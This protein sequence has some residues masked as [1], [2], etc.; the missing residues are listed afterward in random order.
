MIIHRT[1]SVPALPARSTCVAL[2]LFD[3]LHIGHRAVLEATLRMAREHGA[4]PLCFT[5]ST[6]GSRPDAK[7]D[8]TRLLTGTQ[9]AEALEAMGFAYM[10]CPP[11][12]EFRGLAPRAFVTGALA[13]T[14]G[15]AGVLCGYDFRFGSGAAGTPETLAALCG[16]LGLAVRVAPA[17]ELDGGPVSSRRIRRLVADGEMEAAARLL[18]RPFSLSLRVERGRGLGRRLGAPTLNQPLPDGLTLPRFGV[19]ASLSHLPGGDICPGVTNVGRRPTVGSEAPLAET[20]LPGYSGDLYGQ[21]VTVELLRFLRAEQRFP[22][23]ESLR[24]QIAAD[25]AAAAAV[26]AAYLEEKTIT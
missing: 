12:D 24:G 22:N 17:V 25:T 13:V 20:F 14:L 19:Y 23:L 11:F 6:Q 15:A 26:A 5:F 4:Q 2:G 10:I 7:A 8:M 9:L 18:G 16:E 1:L 21:R 3:G